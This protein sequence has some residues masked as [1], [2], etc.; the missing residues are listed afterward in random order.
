MDEEEIR[1]VLR[2]RWQMERMGP[3]D[4]ESLDREVRAVLQHAFMVNEMS[5][6]ILFGALKNG[7]IGIAEFKRRAFNNKPGG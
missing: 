1:R 2:A 4:E 7:R 6:M 5:R 3:L